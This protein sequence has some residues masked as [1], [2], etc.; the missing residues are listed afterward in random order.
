MHLIKILLVDDDEDDF[1]LT[2]NILSS[3]NDGNYYEVS[4]CNNYTEAINAMLKSH[5]DIYLVDYRLGKHSGL[6]LLY[7]AT[8]SNCTEPII[9]FTGRGDSKIDEEALRIGAADYL[10]KDEINSEIL[11][12]TIRYALRHH[13]A[14][15]Q[16]KNSENKFRA[17]FERSKDPIMITDSDG[18]IYEANEAAIRFMDTTFEELIR[19]NSNDFYK[20]LSDREI[21]CAAMEQYGSV[22]DLE[23]EII[24]ALGKTK[25]CSI[26]SF[27]QI[28][29]HGH[30]EFYYSIL[31]D[32]TYRKIQEQKSLY[33]EKIES[34]GHLTRIVANEIYSP[35][36]N[37]NFATEELKNNSEGRDENML[38]DIIR[39]NCERINEI[40]SSILAKAKV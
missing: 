6:D 21:F 3:G 20:N 5:Y 9:I 24:S 16:L 37:I 1:L 22:K 2:R 10:T 11:A 15:S 14:L 30:K 35:L 28:S 39:K 19:K 32:I 25:Y 17:L 27:L 38:I 26:S 12:R 7:E 33:E 36:S 4:W 23:L 18:I 13:K 29:Q 31:H 34:I 40:T 8:K